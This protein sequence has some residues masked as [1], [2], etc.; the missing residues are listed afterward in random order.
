M[1]GHAQTE[2]ATAPVLMIDTCVWLDLAKEY[3]QRALLSA[4]ETLF[5]RKEIELIVPELVL[6]ELEHNK[7]RIV[8][9]SGR[10]LTAALKRARE[11][12][13]AFGDKRRKKAALQEMHE[14][15]L[16]LLNLGDQAAEMFNRVDALLSASEKI[17]LTDEVKIR[18]SNR[19]LTK[20]APF[21]RQRNGMADAIMIEMYA[22]AVATAEKGQWLG[23]VTHNIKDFSHPTSD[24]RLPHPDIAGLFSRVKSRYFITLGEA[25]R[26]L[27]SEEY[28]DLMIEQ[29]WANRPSRRL[30]EI[31]AAEDEHFNKVWYNRHMV[32]REKVE[33]GTIKIVDKENAK[34]NFIIERTVQRDIWDGALEAAAKVEKRFGIENLGPWDDFEWGMVNGKLSAL[35]WVLGDDWDMLDT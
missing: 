18:A 12:M 9:E 15:D 1:V 25:L 29:E 14:V 27:G 10:S 34:D 33:D 19:A 20:Q 3:N 32:R 13:A 17:P 2:K 28:A 23:F 6:D 26:A 30:S 8:E 21:H 4:L 31:L 24:H 5:E 11:A 16:K 35:R 22:D 7:A